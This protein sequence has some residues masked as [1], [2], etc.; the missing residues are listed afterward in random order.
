MRKSQK[1]QTALVNAV[2]EMI[3][4][5]EKISVSS[6]SKKSKTAYGTFYRYFN[7]LDEIHHSS[8]IKVVTG[9]AEVV[10]LELRNEKSNLFKIYYSWYVA[11]RLYQDE[12]MANWLI[13]NPNSIN[14]AWV[15]TQPMTSQF[16][17]DAIAQK[18]EP[19]LSKDNLRHFKM[20]QTYIFWTYQN[21]L[22]ELL[23]G[24]KPIHVY[25]DLMNSVNLIN[26]PRKTHKKYIQR[27][28]R[29]VDKQ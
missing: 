5:G 25:S 4:K 15:L 10:D 19:D 21:A 16:L 18:E 27:V 1:T 8:I 22:R 3:N 14:E 24:R 6:I 2:I 7:N 26:L 17:A 28:Q 12:Y 11:I 9:A 23:K 20:A 13:T 29:F